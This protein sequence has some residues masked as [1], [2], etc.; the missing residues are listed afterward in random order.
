[1]T[2]SADF[3]TSR[4]C[5][6]TIKVFPWS[7]SLR[8]TSRSFVNIGKMETGRGFVQNVDGSSGRFLGEFRCEFNALS[9]APGELRARLPKRQI[10]QADRYQRLKLVK[11]RRHIPEKPGGL[12]HGH[13]QDVGDVLAAVGDLQSLAIVPRASADFALDI[14]IC[15]K[16]HFDFDDTVSLA[17]LASASFQIKTES[18]AVVA[19]HTGSRQLAEK[20][21]DRSKRAG[22]SGRI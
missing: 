13:F 5:S 15:Q 9:L 18:S 3:I 22:I 8:S 21:A 16:M 1:M 12:I 6:I 10:T 17:I 7:R 11:Y 14:D 2:Q 4:L 20:F 19:A